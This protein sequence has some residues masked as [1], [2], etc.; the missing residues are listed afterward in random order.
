[1][2]NP[3]LTFCHS[4]SREARD[5]QAATNQQLPTWPWCRS[6]ELMPSTKRRGSSQ[7][8]CGEAERP[9]VSA[10]IRPPPP[11]DGGPR[12]PVGLLKDTCCLTRSPSPG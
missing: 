6:W 10:E 9:Q 3:G 12:G 7:M 4:A 5:E 8:S 11:V 2:S 1:M